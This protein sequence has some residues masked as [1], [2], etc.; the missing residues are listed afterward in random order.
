[1]RTRPKLRKKTSQ[2]NIRIKKRLLYPA[3][4]GL[5]VWI[6]FIWIMCSYDTCRSGLDMLADVLP[7]AFV[8]VGVFVMVFGIIPELWSLIFDGSNTE[9]KI[10]E[11]PKAASKPRA[12]TIK[13]VQPVA[14]KVLSEADV[15]Q[16]A[17]KRALDERKKVDSLAGVKLGSKEVLH[18]VLN[19]LKN[20]KGVH[21]ESLLGVLGSLAG[22]SCHMAVREEFVDAGKR[23]PMAVFT[24]VG[25]K[26]GRSY[27]YGDA[28]NK[29]LA[30][31]AYSIW[32]LM[33]GILQHLGDSGAPDLNA[34]FSSVAGKVGGDQFGIPDVPENHRPGDLPI[35]Y[36]KSLWKVMQPV[37]DNY[38]DAPAE[39]P[40]LL[41]LCIQQAIEMGKD[42]IA[43]SL[44]VKLVMEC[45]IPMSKI[46]PEWLE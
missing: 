22:Y 17:L 30:E 16:D 26:D 20:E 10:P 19:A 27:Y 38:C 13:P 8:C 35:N 36:V 7:G 21:I 25:G 5:A 1:M 34:I 28:P 31:D 15:I 33:L 3:S 24:V 39:R 6:I 45:A 32:G 18:K 11:Q 41:G 23:E 12:Q 37:L 4:L 9:W 42:V 40:I 2:I 46:G 44:A 29:P 43:P 14:K